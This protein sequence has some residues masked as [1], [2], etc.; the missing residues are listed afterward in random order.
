LSSF[1]P[2][3]TARLKSIADFIEIR[4]EY[5]KRLCLVI[6]LTYF[7]GR[8]IFYA[9][10]I[11]PS[12]PPDE[13]THLGI[14]QHF[15]GYALLPPDTPQSWEF[16]SVTHI[17]YLYYFIMG[18][19]LGLFP[20]H[21]WALVV[22]RLLNALFSFI[23]V[24]FA[25]RLSR[26]VAGRKSWVPLLTVAALTNTPMFSF[27]SATV[28]YDNLANLCAVMALYYFTCVL[29]ARGKSA[30]LKGLIAILA[31]ILTKVTLLPL[32]LLLCG[33]LAIHYRLKKGPITIQQLKL[34]CIALLTQ[35]KILLGMNL[36]L[37]L[38]FMQLYGL[39]YLRYGRL[40][41][42][43]DQVLTMEQCLRNRIYARNKILQEFI[44]NR[45]SYEQALN[46]TNII[47]HPQDKAATLYLLNNINRWKKNPGP[48]MDPVNY[49]I[50]WCNLMLQGIMA[51]GGHLTI[52]QSPAFS[53]FILLFALCVLFSAAHKW[54]F[55]TEAPVINHLVAVTIGYA[56]ILCAYNYQIFMSFLD[57][58]IAVQGRYLFPVIVPVWILAW[59]FISRI[60]LPYVKPAL[61]LG[62]VLTLFIGDFPNF[63]MHAGRDWY[64]N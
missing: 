33:A 36:F 57:F 23:S 27:L 44:N 15:S 49:L 42:Q 35:S 30:L 13:I 4:Q 46:A 32:M 7:A 1:I 63:L 10:T 47:H 8:L 24:L 28:N 39:N 25:L 21:K 40:V 51:S 31:G 37:L 50:V 19:I 22:L 45:L 43:D 9:F 54:K 16:G 20:F 29:L 6:L 3:L 58:N 59:T 2:V 12:I 48:T 52:P 38:L 41:P 64:I 62:I 60:G 5:F 61:G 17:P 55:K 56:A 34:T 11:N 26:N 18:K 53:G 14:I